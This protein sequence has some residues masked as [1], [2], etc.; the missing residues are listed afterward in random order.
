[1]LRYFAPLF[2]LQEVN[3]IDDAVLKG[4]H[5]LFFSFTIKYKDLINNGFYTTAEE[6]EFDYMF[7][8]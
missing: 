2:L 5:A 1:V 7:K 6:S 3:T 8:K 4:F